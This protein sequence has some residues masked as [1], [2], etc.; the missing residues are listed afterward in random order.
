MVM[1]GGSSEPALLY[2][3]GDSYIRI[4]IYRWIPD[5][6]NMETS[7]WEGW[8]YYKRKCLVI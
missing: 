2:Y 6:C 4:R 3:S 5:Q 1:G 7:E 8:G